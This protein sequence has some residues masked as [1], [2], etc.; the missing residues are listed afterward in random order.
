MDTAIG[1]WKYVR[2]RIKVGT[3]DGRG[4]NLMLL[5]R[6][7]FNAARRAAADP[8]IRAR[9]ADVFESRIKPSATAAW[10]ETKPRLDAARDNIK[11]AAA[12]VDPRSDP[13]GFAGELKRRMAEK[14]RREGDR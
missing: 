12:M 6:L 9:A 10:A 7:L 4:V 1:H 5:R 8:R 2:R 14:R 11:K 3:T 13:A